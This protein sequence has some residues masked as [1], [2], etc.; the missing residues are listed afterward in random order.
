MNKT[1]MYAGLDA[2]IEEIDRLKRR[3]AALEEGAPPI[4]YEHKTVHDCPD[5]V[6]DEMS[7]DGWELYHEE[8]HARLPA[9]G[10]VTDGG[11]ITI[12]PTIYVSASFRRPLTHTPSE[13][14]KE[15][16]AEKP[17]S[18]SFAQVLETIFDDDDDGTPPT[19]ALPRIGDDDDDGGPTE[20]IA[21]IKPETEPAP[22]HAY[23]VTV[24]NHPHVSPFARALANPGMLANLDRSTI[25]D[26]L[27]EGKIY[28]APD[29]TQRK[30]ENG[31]V[32]SLKPHQR[33]WRVDAAATETL[34]LI[35]VASRARARQAEYA[36][37][38]NQ[39]EII[40]Q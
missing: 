33:I 3:V 38:D 31:L 8:H 23:T 37:T 39:P 32:M 11:P 12:T 15:H 7:A 5:D 1:V 35:G 14:V 2:L 18:P 4:I 27:E 29:G 9:V 21:P 19:T 30:I 13:P 34:A 17:L 36:R 26:H 6:K 25:P 20:P 10:K 16:S 22:A 40:Y 28:T 24:R